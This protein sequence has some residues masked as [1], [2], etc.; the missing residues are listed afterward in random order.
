[1][2][3][4]SVAPGAVHALDVIATRT[5]I[6]RHDDDLPSSEINDK[7]LVAASEGTHSDKFSPLSSFSVQ[8][9]SASS[10]GVSV[11]YYEIVALGRRRDGSPGQ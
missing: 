1:M 9:P 5:F 2:C 4:L 3:G 6:L 7:V 10:A 8:D 11:P